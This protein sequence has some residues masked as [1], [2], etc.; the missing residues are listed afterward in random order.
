MLLGEV[1]SKLSSPSGFLPSSAAWPVAVAAVLVLLFE[2]DSDTRII[3]TRR[4]T[5]L[6][7]HPG[8]VAFP[9]GMVEVGEELLTAALRETK[10]EIALEPDEIKVIGKLEPVSTFSSS[11]TVQPFVGV[12]AKRPVLVPSPVEVARIFDVSLVELANSYN[13]SIGRYIHPLQV[14]R[15]QGEIIWGVT[16]RIVLNLLLS[17]GGLLSEVR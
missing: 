10:E 6:R 17:I 16:A 11:L 14:F 8:E 3:L 5:S 9:G 15:V 13:V 12:L 2:E 7:T 1:I 4:S